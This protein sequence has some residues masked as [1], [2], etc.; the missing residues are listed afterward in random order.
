MRIS[1]GEAHNDGRGHVV[2]K[3]EIT[4]DNGFVEQGCYI[5]PED[6]LEWRAAEYDL[7]PSD[8]DSI[9]EIVLAECHL[10]PVPDEDMPVL[11][12][13]DTIV[14]ARTKH[15]DRCGKTRDKHFGNERAR[16]KKV[17]PST[18]NWKEL[19]VMDPEALELKKEIVAKARRSV[20]EQRRAAK[21][22]PGAERIA[23]LRNQL[24]N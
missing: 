5:F 3:R 23:R 19:F 8:M 1:L 11:F 12:T 16:G 7:D 2:I 14:E 22:N 24:E 15:V 10:D 4:H 9:M 20:R 13:A 21:D 6:T 17:T 18:S